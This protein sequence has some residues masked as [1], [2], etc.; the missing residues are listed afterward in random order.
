LFLYQFVHNKL[1]VWLGGLTL[2]GGIMYR[3][4]N[5]RGKESIGSSLLNKRMEEVAKE[6]IIK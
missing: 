1:V 5:D 2:E 4:V 6:Y 3:I